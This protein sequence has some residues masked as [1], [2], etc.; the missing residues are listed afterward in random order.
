MIRHR[1]G[2]RVQKIAGDVAVVDRL[3]DRGDA[4]GGE[5]FGGIAQIGDIAALG[6]GAVVTVG[7]EPSH[8]VHQPALCRLGIG[9]CRVDPGAELRLAPGQG[10]HA[11]LALGPVAWRHVEQGLGQPVFFELGGGG[12]GRMVVG[13]E[14]FDRLEPAF[15]GRRKAVEKPDFLED[16]TQIGGEFRHE[17]ALPG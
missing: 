3:D 14:I 12:F 17:A 2:R 15:G 7:H 13:A 16:K 5:P 8:G 6:L 9:Q 1:L 4:F 11:A 10:R